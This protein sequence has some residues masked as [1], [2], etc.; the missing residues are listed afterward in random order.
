MSMRGC[1]DRPPAFALIAR[2]GSSIHHGGAAIRQCVVG[3]AVVTHCSFITLSDTVEPCS[4]F[5]VIL[6]YPPTVVG[7][8]VPHVAMAVPED[9]HARR[10]FDAGPA[11]DVILVTRRPAK[12]G[13]RPSPGPVYIHRSDSTEQFDF[14]I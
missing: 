9:D 11:T 5:V 3:P 10:F 2:Y 4:I 13:R 7:P 8:F 6:P 12:W 14:T 1:F